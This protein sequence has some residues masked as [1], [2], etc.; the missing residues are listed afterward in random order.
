MSTR[1]SHINR[2]HIWVQELVCIQPLSLNYPVKM[3]QIGKLGH[4]FYSTKNIYYFSSWNFCFYSL[5][6]ML[7]TQKQQPET[8]LSPPLK[9]S[10]NVF[11]KVPTKSRRVNR[12]RKKIPRTRKIRKEKHYRKKTRLETSH[13]L[14]S[15]LSSTGIGL[16]LQKTARALPPSCKGDSVN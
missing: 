1:I 15:S 5:V 3:E 9:S 7:L 2:Y 13:S 8:E 11:A 6:V 14:K 12:T 16:F 10:Q 4:S